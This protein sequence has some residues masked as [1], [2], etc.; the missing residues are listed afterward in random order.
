MFA[1]QEPLEQQQQ[2]QYDDQQQQQQLLSDGEV[3]GVYVVPPTPGS[4]LSAGAVMVEESDCDCDSPYPLT[5]TQ[6][7]RGEAFA[8][9]VQH[10]Q[11]QQQYCIG[12]RQLQ[13]HGEGQQQE[14]GKLGQHVELHANQHQQQY[15]RYE[16]QQQNQPYSQQ[17]QQQQQ[18][19]EEEVVVAQRCRPE[20]EGVQEAT[21]QEKHQQQQDGDDGKKQHRQHSNEEQQLDLGMGGAAAEEAAVTPREVEEADGGLTWVERCD[22]L[23]QSSTTDLSVL[24]Q[25]LQQHLG[26]LVARDGTSSLLSGGFRDRRRGTEVPGGIRGD[27]KGLS[28][29]PPPPQFGVAATAGGGTAGAGWPNV[30]GAGVPP[31]MEPDAKV[32][33]ASV[34]CLQLPSSGGFPIAYSNSS[35]SRVLPQGLMG[36]LRAP[37]RLRF[38]NHGAH[39]V[40]VELLGQ[41]KQELQVLKQVLQAG[42]Q[43]MAAQVGGGIGEQ[44]VWDSG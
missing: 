43:L 27:S 25:L 19:E 32:A 26:L 3:G 14:Q 30:S 1:S 29:T 40:E 34:I 7:P 24:P 36:G 33:A 16:Q 5:L 42:L 44:G 11:Q 9:A 21:D 20:L 37:G 39:V 2:Q 23:V 6:V 35:S 17:Q 22:L 8:A 4:V 41:D 28:L 15:M 12:G 18:Q 38:R 31:E 10:Q 13:Q